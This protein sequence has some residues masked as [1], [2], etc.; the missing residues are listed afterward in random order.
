MIIRENKLGEIKMLFS[1]EPLADAQKVG[2]LP[3]MWPT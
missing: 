1:K 3:S 2:S